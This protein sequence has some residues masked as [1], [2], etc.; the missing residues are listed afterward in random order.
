MMKTDDKTNPMTLVGARE[1]L[2]CA[3]TGL[4]T[5]SA[6]PSTVIRWFD[7]WRF[8]D[9]FDHTRVYYSPKFRT[10]IILTEPYHSTEHALF[11]VQE[12]AEVRGGDYSFAIGAAGSGIWYPGSCFPL[13]IARTG[14][15]DLLDS[16][17]SLLP[18]VILEPA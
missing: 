4:R 15:G 17:A 14:F 1:H 7:Y 9:G 18:T 5:S 8:P 3:R 6:R 10:H 13:L 2:W 16:F 12:M 11:S